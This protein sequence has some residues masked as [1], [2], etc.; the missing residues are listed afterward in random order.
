MRGA[1]LFVRRSKRKHRC[2]WWRWGKIN[3]DSQ[4]IADANALPLGVCILL[5]AIHH[6]LDYFWNVRLLELPALLCTESAKT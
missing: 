1:V 4:H 3:G 5:Y 6:N 2:R